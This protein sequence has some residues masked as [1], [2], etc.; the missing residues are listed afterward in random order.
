MPRLR[1]R[2][3]RYEPSVHATI[4]LLLGPIED[5]LTIDQLRVAWSVERERLMRGEHPPG[6]RP[7]AFYH[8]DLGDPMP[9]SGHDEA[10]RLAELGLLTDRELAAFGKRA[11]E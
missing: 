6:K 8:F 3:W 10:V 9:A 5:G 1:E 7:W 4:D 2:G 11:I